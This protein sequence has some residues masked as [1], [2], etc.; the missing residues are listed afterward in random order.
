MDVLRFDTPSAANLINLANDRCIKLIVLED[1]HAADLIHQIESFRAV[2]GLTIWAVAYRDVSSGR[3]FFKRR[4]E[5]D[6]LSDLRLLSM[7]VPIDV[8]TSMFRL[9]LYG[10][11]IIP[12]ELMITQEGYL[13]APPPLTA[14]TSARQILTKREVEVL[15]LVSRGDCNKTIAHDL[16][17]SEHTIKLHMHHILNKI[18]A[19]NRTAASS[20]YLSQNGSL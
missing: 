15:S 8:W 11:Y 4:I 13:T 12:C 9:A 10:D 16:G 17:L 20:W 2:A 7:N 18:G 6:V 3:A 14:S 19:S 1:V 5:S